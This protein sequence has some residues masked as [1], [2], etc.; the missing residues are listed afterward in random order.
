MY[1][2]L[3][4]QLRTK[5]NTVWAEPSQKITYSTEASVYKKIVGEFS[6]I[7]EPSQFGPASPYERMLT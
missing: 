3:E 4:P 6:H 5:T 2:L 7:H 1:Q